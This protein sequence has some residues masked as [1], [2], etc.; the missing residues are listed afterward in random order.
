[1]YTSE[2]TNVLGA[3]DGT[4]IRI[5]APHEHPQVYVNRK[6]FHSIVRQGI[7]ANN[8]QFLHVVA[9]W[10]GSVNDSRILRNCDI[11]NTGPRWCGQNNHFVR[12]GAYPFRNWLLKPFRDNGHLTS[13]QR[14][15][16]YRLS[17]RVATE[18][19]FG[20]LKGRFRRLK[21]LDAKSIITAV[22]TIIVC[23]I[24]HN[25][26]VINDDILDHITYG[27]DQEDPPLLARTFSKL[28]LWRWGWFRKA[29]PYW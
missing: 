7:C 9:G 11:W 20:I 24:F 5:V 17:A 25:M 18:C 2:F 13:Q 12:D 3:I 16:N 19:A 21:L 28:V 8:L 6:K 1:M 10:P 23:C 15:F 4:H 26:C 29:K 27:R 22:D 14:R